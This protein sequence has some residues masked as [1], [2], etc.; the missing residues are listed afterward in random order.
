MIRSCTLVIQFRLLP[1][2]PQNHFVLHKMR[3]TMARIRYSAGKT[4]G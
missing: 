1:I 3:Q 2:V 4:A